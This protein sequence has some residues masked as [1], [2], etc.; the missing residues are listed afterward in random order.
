MCR[1]RADA[2][3]VHCRHINMTCHLWLITDSAHLPSDREEISPSEPSRLL[4]PVPSVPFTL[5]TFH[6]RNLILT[7]LMPCIMP[8]P[9]QQ[10]PDRLQMFL[11]ADKPA[12]PFARHIVMPE[13]DMLH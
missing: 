8:Q 6:R 11:G 2:V 13:G 7:S 4:G 9:C 5:C 12:F 3:G 1:R 10:L